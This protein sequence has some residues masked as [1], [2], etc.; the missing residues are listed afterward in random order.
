VVA[1]VSPPPSHV[2]LRV[3]RWTSDPNEIA[4]QTLVGDFNR[5]NK[6]SLR[7]HILFSRLRPITF[8]HPG[9]SEAELPA[10]RVTGRV[11]RMAP[12]RRAAPGEASAITGRWRI[13]KPGNPLPRQLG[14]NQLAPL[15][16]RANFG[17]I[18]GP[19]NNRAGLV[20]RRTAPTGSP[21]PI[22]RAAGG[23]RGADRTPQSSNIQSKSTTA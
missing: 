19:G 18:P 12:V 4:E 22:S 7:K 2:T 9:V 15:T 13:A 1:P 8:M 3:D 21:P 11:N 6:M 10:R 14:P 17:P 23:N 16:S 20:A 5:N